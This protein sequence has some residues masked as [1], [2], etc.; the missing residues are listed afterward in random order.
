MPRAKRQ[1]NSA[2][3]RCCNEDHVDQDGH[4]NRANVQDLIDEL[5]NN[6]PQDNI[7]TNTEANAEAEPQVQK[8][9]KRSAEC[10][11]YGK[12]TGPQSWQ[13]NLC[14]HAYA[15]GAT[16]FTYAY[17]QPCTINWFSKHIVYTGCI[18]LATAPRST[19]AYLQPSQS[20]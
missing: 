18:L 13:C 3:E 4:V 1:R 5:E 6:D 14:K 12:K 11:Q 16:R 2:P 10:W 20:R 8:H 15:G 9:G 7:E 17:L 19:H